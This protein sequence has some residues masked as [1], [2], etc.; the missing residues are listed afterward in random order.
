MKYD[1]T[2]TDRPLMPVELICKV[3][4]LTMP[5]PE[6][7]FDDARRWR[8]DYCWPEQKVAL[9]IE[10]GVFTR[11]RHTRPTGFL[12]DMEKYNRAAELGYRIFRCT[13]TT[14]HVGMRLVGRALL[15]LN[16]GAETAG[17]R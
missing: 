1:V 14:I 3:D 12:K 4:G 2:A 16:D 5:K 15:G 13:P 7:R 11:G 9:E 10:G 17:A 6:F 8:F